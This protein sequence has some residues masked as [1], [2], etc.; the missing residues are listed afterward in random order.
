[1][2]NSHGKFNCWLKVDSIYMYIHN[3]A[4]PPAMCGS[5]FPC[6]FASGGH[7]QAATFLLS[8]VVSETEHLPMFLKVLLYLSLTSLNNFVHFIYLFIL[9]GFR[10]PCL[11]FF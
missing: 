11:Q 8:P 3:F 10:T 4:F 7:C 1:M 5:V 9:S 2:V 6:S